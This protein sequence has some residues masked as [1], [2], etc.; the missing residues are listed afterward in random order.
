MSINLPNGFGGT[1]G[2]GIVLSKPLQLSG[3]VWYVNSTTGTD[4][5]SPAGKER[6]KPL[7]T[8]SQ[9]HTNA[10]SGDVV[11]FL[12]THTE[13][14]TSVVTLSK[15]LT[16]I[17]EGSASGLP[18]VK[19]FNNS[20]TAIMW[21]LTGTGAFHVHNIYFGQNVQTGTGSK[22]S[23]LTPSDLVIRN[24]YFDQGALDDAAAVT[25]GGSNVDIRD[26]PFVSSGTSI[27]AQPLMA[28]AGSGTLDHVTMS[29]VSI[30]GGLYGW[31][32]TYAVDFAAGTS[33]SE[34]FVTSMSLLNSSLMQVFE[35]T[36]GYLNISTATG[37][38]RV[39]WC[40]VT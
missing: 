12:A 8:L 4:A 35:A 17:G 31:S 24:C 38:A 36:M 39:D 34:L 22:V 21:S 26:T 7:A 16:L 23:A 18:T 30:D 33:V 20:A 6:S 19:F 27:S 29:G 37:G 40:D 25:L 9:A 5:V 32:N 13:T 2:N 14:F 15:D 10:A 1:A 28:I 11:V 3:N